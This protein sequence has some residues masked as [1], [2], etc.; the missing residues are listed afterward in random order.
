[1]EVDTIRNGGNYF[2]DMTPFNNGAKHCFDGFDTEIAIA[3]EFPDQ[4]HLL[5]SNGDQDLFLDD[6]QNSGFITGSFETGFKPNTI[7]PQAIWSEEHLQQI[8]SQANGFGFPQQLVQQEGPLP[9][10]PIDN[11][12]EGPKPKHDT[13]GHGEES[14]APPR[15]KRG[16]KKGKKKQLSE[17][18]SMIK[19][20]KLLERNRQAASKCRLKKK[21]LTQKLEARAEELS[22]EQQSL[23]LE[24]QEVKEET[25][26]LHRDLIEHANCNNPI[27]EEFLK[28]QAAV[29]ANPPEQPQYTMMRTATQESDIILGGMSPDVRMPITQPSRRSGSFAFAYHPHSLPSLD[30]GD[31]SLELPDG[32][33]H[34]ER[35]QNSDVLQEG[36][37][38]MSRQESGASA[39]SV[40]DS[41]ISNMGTPVRL[42]FDPAQFDE[43]FA[44]N[45]PLHVAVI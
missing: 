1:M 45:M 40:G 3:N 30:T 5:T 44:S 38:S 33:L 41:G 24:F 15:L 29:A 16:R 14:P 20:D 21:G 36:S 2:G 9:E 35:N 37:I 34:E 13:K 31:L 4:P 32:T 43:G 22:L 18:E 17:E 27:I 42:K 26:K 19:R 12:L 11:I 7:S 23:L 39:G 8:F 28:V 10:D 25:M 6:F